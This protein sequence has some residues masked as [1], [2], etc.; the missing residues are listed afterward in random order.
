[1]KVIVTGGA[2]FIGS[3]L[4]KKLIGE[5]NYEVLVI[6]SLTY[7]SQLESLEEVSS[8]ALFSLAQEDICNQELIEKIFFDF[9]PNYIFNLAAE[10]HVDRSIDSPDLFIKTNI[11]G[12][13][14]LL[15]SSYK[16]W[17]TLESSLK[18]DFRFL[19]V[20]T[21]EVFGD[22]GDDDPPCDELKNY[23][24]SSPYSATK[25]SSD[26]LVRAWHKTYKLPVLL[27]N[28][29]NNYG[30]FQFYEKLIPLMIIKA[31]RGEELPV[32]GS[33]LQIRDW[34]FVDDHVDALIRI[35]QNGEIGESY[36]IGANCEKTNL[37]VVNEI[38]RILDETYE[39]KPKDIQSFRD[40]ITFVDDRPGHDKRYA[41]N[42][43]KIRS[44][45]GWEPRENFES[46]LKKTIQ[47][48]VN[49]GHSIDYEAL[50]IGKRR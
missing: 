8:S 10:T 21:D 45:L 26:H 22:L 15:E 44:K 6:D 12:T 17:E 9:K 35:I 43:Q 1:M 18:E 3:A 16:Y 36:N 4:V 20:S 28:C 46:G 25:A 29:S 13:Y 23:D 41:I 30:P 32:Y 50:R 48:Y 11:F 42:P 31:I 37:E 34:L 2:G 33:G 5:F 7:A 49:K 47:W 19:H 27:S 24:P 14:S 39:T 38:C 40:L